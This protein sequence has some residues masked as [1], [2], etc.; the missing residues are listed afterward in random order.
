LLNPK[1]IGFTA[2]TENFNNSR[3]LAKI[4]KEVLPESII[5][6][7]GPHPTFTVEETLADPDIDIVIKR[8]GEITMYN[9]A[10]SIFDNQFNLEK[11]KGLAFK[12][13]GEIVNN[14]DRDFIENLD[15][16]P[17]PVRNAMDYRGVNIWEKHPTI[18]TSRGCPFRCVFCAAAAMSGGKYRLRSPDNIYEEMKLLKKK[19]P[20]G[21]INIAD[22]TF[23]ANVKRL[24]IILEKIKSLNVSWTCES[25]VDVLSSERGKELAK[26]MADA[27][28]FSLQFGIE[29]GNQTVLNKIKK[30]ITLEQI[31]KAIINVRKYDIEVMGSMMIGLPNETPEQTKKTIEFAA[32]LEK[33]YDI[34]ILIGITTP[35][36]G[37]SL[38]NHADEFGIEILTKDY[39]FYNVSNPVMKTTYYT[40]DELRN[41]HADAIESLSKF[42][43]PAK[44]KKLGSYFIR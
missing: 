36:P 21:T 41:T 35:F 38:W 32:Y 34:V 15:I 26:E 30:G 42:I 17:F 16:L 37:T 31:E 1:I 6:F 29:S 11:I 22:D 28:C 24:L 10:K 12:R 43:D 5:V 27:G 2:V 3:R 19:Y 33:E 44:I 4:C 8:E 13:H 39:D 7:G 40:P 20:R 18:I 14:I 25:R 9:L 23:T